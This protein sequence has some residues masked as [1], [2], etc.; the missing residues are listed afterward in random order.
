MILAGSGLPAATWLFHLPPCFVLENGI[1]YDLS[2]IYK[3]NVEYS[4]WIKT[5][6]STAHVVYDMYFQL[7]IKN[8]LVFSHQSRVFLT[9]NGNT[10]NI[11]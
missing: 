5:Y 3:Y 7:V 4:E 1:D 6:I 11:F 9:E 10:E 8:F 2:T